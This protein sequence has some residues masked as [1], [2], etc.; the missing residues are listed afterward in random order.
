MKS[1]TFSHVGPQFVCNMW[2]NFITGSKSSWVQGEV[3]LNL[4]KTQYAKLFHHTAEENCPSEKS[5]CDKIKPN[6]GTDFY[7]VI[8][9]LRKDIFTQKYQM[10]SREITWNF[11]RKCLGLFTTKIKIQ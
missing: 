6:S 11:Q 4:C 2:L 3:F 8:L 10:C 5:T 9:E 1:G 7:V